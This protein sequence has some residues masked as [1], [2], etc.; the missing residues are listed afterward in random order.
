MFGINY[1]S[2]K[3]EA[4]VNVII[5]R[6]AYSGVAFTASKGL[7]IEW[8]KNPDRGLPKPDIVLQE[9]HLLKNKIRKKSISEK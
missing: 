4:G 8:C 5:D 2:E 1:R 6:Y 9:L 7:D 3:L